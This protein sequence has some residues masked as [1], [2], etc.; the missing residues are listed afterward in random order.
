[1][2]PIYACGRHF[3][4]GKEGSDASVIVETPTPNEDDFG[5]TQDTNLSAEVSPTSH[6]TQQPLTPY[7]VVLG[8]LHVS[9]VSFSEASPVSSPSLPTPASTHELKTTCTDPPQSTSALV[10]QPLFA[11]V[12]TTPMTISRPSL[13]LQHPSTLSLSMEG[14]PYIPNLASSEGR[15]SVDPL[16]TADPQTPFSRVT[17]PTPVTYSGVHIS[18]SLSNS[19]TSILTTVAQTAS[20]PSVTQRLYGDPSSLYVALP[21]STVAL[22]NQGGIHGNTHDHFRVLSER[23]SRGI[24]VSGTAPLIPNQS[25]AVEMNRLTGRTALTSNDSVAPLATHIPL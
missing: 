24:V 5:V 3:R 14:L 6:A 2:S 9:R 25:A 18:L 22:A 13:S 19:T 4:T 1:M 11:P 21:T 10:L 7:N 8:Q 17:F 15:S 23:G 12:S 16:I 20:S